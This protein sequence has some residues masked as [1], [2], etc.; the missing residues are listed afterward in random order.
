VFVGLDV[1]QQVITIISL[2]K[3][4]VLHL[5]FLAPFN[6]NDTSGVTKSIILASLN[7]KK[8]REESIAIVD[9]P[10]PPHF[11]ILDHRVAWICGPSLTERLLV[12][13][14]IKKYTIFVCRVC[15]LNIN[16]Q[17]RGATLVF[18]RCDCA[19]FHFLSLCKSL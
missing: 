5:S 8:G 17:K 6:C 12:H 11:S 19:T 4:N 16:Y 14:A 13:V 1:I 18:Q 15:G 10:T 2:I 7:G 3:T 9:R